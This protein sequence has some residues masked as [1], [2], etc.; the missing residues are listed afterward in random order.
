ML[1]RLCT[2]VVWQ[3]QI[4]ACANVSCPDEGVL[5]SQLSELCTGCLLSQATGS[6]GPP[7]IEGCLTTCTAGTADLDGDPSTPC[8]VCSVG[9]FSEAGAESCSDCAAGTADVDEDPATDCETCAAG[10][11]SLA[12]STSCTSCVDLPRCIGITSCTTNAT[13]GRSCDECATGYFPDQGQ[14]GGSCAEN[15]CLEFFSTYADVPEGYVVENNVGTTLSSL[16]VVA[17]DDGFTTVVDAE[18]PH[19]H[20]LDAIILEEMEALCQVEYA[21]CSAEC[22]SSIVTIPSHGLDASAAPEVASLVACMVQTGL[23]SAPPALISCPTNGRAFTPLT[24]CVDVNECL[25]NPCENGAV[26]TDSTSDAAVPA[27]GYRCTCADGY[28]SGW[29]E[30]DQIVPE[31]VSNCSIIV[32][33]AA[34]QAGDGN[35]AIDVN[36]CASNPCQ[37]GG[38]CTETNISA[39]ACICSEINNTRTGLRVSHDGEQCENEIDVCAYGED[40]CDPYHA[41]CHHTGPGQHDC[42]CHVGWEGDGHTCNDIDECLSNPCQNGICSHSACDVSAFPSGTVC[43]AGVGNDTRPPIDAYRC[44]CEA[45]WANGICHPDWNV[46]GDEIVVEYFDRCN[47]STGGNCDVDMN[48]CLSNPCQNSAACSD[49]TTEDQPTYSYSCACL[50][51]FT[52]GECT[53]T[54]SV[55]AYSQQCAIASTAQATGSEGNCGVDVNECLS[56]PCQNGAACS[57]SSTD[58]ELPTDGYRCS[59]VDGFASGLC[60]YNMTVPGT[61]IVPAVQASCDI[62]FSTNVGVG[63]GEGNCEVDVDECLSNPC[64]NGGACSEHGV[65]EWV[66]TCAIVENERTANT[67]TELRVGFNG[68]R[69][70][71]EIEVCSIEEDNCDPYHATCH[72]TGPGQHDCTCHVGWEGDG[73]T[74]NDIDECLS[75]PC[76]NGGVCSESACPPSVFNADPALSGNN[77]TAGIADDSR[78]PPNTYRCNCA[79]GYANGVCDDGWDDFAEIQAQY[80]VSCTQMT[81]GY[82]DVDINECLS[83]PCQNNAACLESIASLGQEV[84]FDAYICACRGGWADGKC[85]YD[86]IPEYSTECNFSSTTDAAAAGFAGT[87][88]VDVDECASNPCEN[89]AVCD[90]STTNSTIPLDAYRCTCTAGFTN[91]VCLYD[92]IS[93]YNFLCGYREGPFG[94][95]QTY[96]HGG[97]CDMDVDE[98]ASRPCQNGATCIESSVDASISFH[99]YQCKCAAGY[100]NGVCEYTG[101]TRERTSPPFGYIV[102]FMDECT[103][104]ETTQNPSLSGNCDIDVDECA[105][106]PCQNDAACS[107]STV[108]SMIGIHAYRCSCVAGFANGACDYQGDTREHASYGFITEYFDECTVLE[109]TENSNTERNWTLTGNC[110]IDVNECA[111]SPCQN[112]AACTDSTVNAILS[113]HAYRCACIAGYANGLCDYEFIAEFA[114]ECNVEESG[115]D[116]TG[117]QLSGNCDIDVD[118]CA[119]SPCQNGATCTESTVEAIVS[120]DAYRCTCT[121]GYANGVCEYYGDSRSRTSPPFGYIVEYFEECTVMESSS[122]TEDADSQLTGNCDIDV[123]ECASEP[124]LNGATCTE[125]T[126]N[127]NIS[128]HSYRCSCTAGFTNGFCEYSTAISEYALNCSVLESNDHPDVSWLSGNC[129][130]DV[131]E[132]DSNPCLGFDS[133]CTDST[134]VRDIGIEDYSCVCAPGF[135]HGQCDHDDG[136]ERCIDNCVEN[137]TSHCSAPYSTIPTSVNGGNCEVDVNECLSSPCQ[138][139]GNCSQIDELEGYACTCPDFAQGWEGPRFGRTLW[140]RETNLRKESAEKSTWLPEYDCEIRSYYDLRCEPGQQPN[141]TLSRGGHSDTGNCEDCPAGRYSPDGAECRECLEPDVVTPDPWWC[142]RR[143]DFEGNVIQEAGPCERRLTCRKCPQGLLPNENRTDCIDA[144]SATLGAA[145]ADLGSTTSNVAT[146][147]VT[148]DLPLRVMPAALTDPALKE[149]LTAALVEALAASM[150]VNIED[151]IVDGLV[152]GRRALQDEAWRAPDGYGVPVTLQFTVRPG[153]RAGAMYAL[154]LDLQDPESAIG[155][156]LSSMGADVE[157]FGIGQRCPEGKVRVGDE[158]LCRKCP[159]PEHTVDRETC[160]RCPEGH[161]PTDKGDGCRCTTGE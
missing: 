119:S 97:N 126:T 1:T 82:C 33:S 105:S 148:G 156:E 78:P 70:E 59:C 128:I 98:C 65:S 152:P 142:R 132:C 114:V 73:H 109:S 112:G 155:R 21:A 23:I 60:D 125:S 117:N 159:Y 13:I 101:D 5:V 57:D 35:C 32:S 79:A 111:S 55:P 149:E 22:I 108:D 137:Y 94:W 26:C 89:G 80:S 39:W 67:E 110:D 50:V 46:H 7:P 154:E 151:I 2:R 54:L 4:V 140:W 100:A 127:A 25:S 91:G 17:C 72:H 14:E 121:S 9:Q 92:F 124:C 113:T 52:S 103:V 44:E 144:L 56:N 86:F 27:N 146:V 3:N 83:T 85:G 8:E 88:G 31:Y 42:T 34:A 63:A 71:N 10:T 138:H 157:N 15:V 81:G 139:D 134:T 49:S 45:G 84:A 96:P 29:C 143:V 116:G 130:T 18:F 43:S 66:C 131:N 129:D 99:A 102:E 11:F 122:P 58:P 87:C 153:A 30:Y 77:C 161:E 19:P 115:G 20:D 123:N 118:E 160:I 90:D 75:N 95:R 104:L 48:E 47:V 51:G 107:D 145:A 6:S 12:G 133:V 53:Y 40:D 93:Q 38:I 36:E 74:C 106:E 141:S 136:K 37:N 61:M 62:H 147:E 28:A 120:I 41:T 64:Q 76:Q 135:I 24:G 16:G 150:G 158:T 69:C 68:E